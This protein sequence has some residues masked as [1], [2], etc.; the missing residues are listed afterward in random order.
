[1]V[2]VWHCIWSKVGPQAMVSPSRA[3][4]NL[5]STTWQIQNTFLKTAWYFA[6]WTIKF[7]QLN[8]F[9]SVVKHADSVERHHP[10]YR[11]TVH[12][13]SITARLKLTNY[14]AQI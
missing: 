14:F 13:K 1:M 2:R 9:D 5:S 12:D 3:T 8:F 6:S 4:G 10:R 7:K 11:H